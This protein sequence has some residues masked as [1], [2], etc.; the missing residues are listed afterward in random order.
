MSEEET[1]T[2]PVN[3]IRVLLADAQPIYANGLSDYLRHEPDTDVVGT[4]AS[5]EETLE[6]AVRLE[7]DVIVMDAHMPP[8]TNGPSLARK[9][10]ELRP[11]TPILVLSSSQSDELV[12]EMIRAGVA[13]H[14]LKSSDGVEVVRAIRAVHRG[15]LYLSSEVVGV[16]IRHIKESVNHARP[17]THRTTPL[18]AREK[19]ILELLASGKKVRE[20]AVILKIRKATV[21]THLHNIR[22]KL[23]AR[24]RTTAVRTALQRGYIEFPAAPMR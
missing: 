14:L 21:A 22:A 17:E 12:V 2:Q 20:I 9:L 10:Q 4:A 24:D 15:E 16:L 23:L 1:T 11:A 13:G 8:Q 3:R 19:Q 7:P 5:G 18:T 6:S